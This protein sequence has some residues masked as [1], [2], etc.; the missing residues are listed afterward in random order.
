MVTANKIRDGDIEAFESLIGNHK[1]KVF[2]YCLRIVN[3]FHLAEE[4]TQDVFV[5]VYQNIKTYNWQKGSLSTWIYTIAHNICINSIRNSSQAISLGQAKLLGHLNS[6]E[7]EYLAKLRLTEMNKAI[8]SLSLEDRSL[9]ILKDYF[10]FKF[11]E[12]NKIMN[13][14]IGT[15]KS[16]LHGI[17]TKLRFSVGDD[18]D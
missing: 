5:K 4:L 2:N 9:L 6:A 11:T 17:R 8:Q 1:T 3:N 16:R 14:P 15:L 7:D 18:Y 10:G 12:I 13:L